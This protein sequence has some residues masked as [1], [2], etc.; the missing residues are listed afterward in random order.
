MGIWYKSDVEHWL[1]FVEKIDSDM[2]SGY[3]IDYKGRFFSETEGH[4][5]TTNINSLNLREATNEE[6]SKALIKEAKKRGFKGKFFYHA[7]SGILF[8][9]PAGCGGKN[10]FDKGE[11]AEIIKEVTVTKQQIADW[12]GV[13]VKNLTIKS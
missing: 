1:M 6:I 13:D 9:A 7:Y 11:W 2:I 10:V 4:D 3:G 8:N 5:N 12:R